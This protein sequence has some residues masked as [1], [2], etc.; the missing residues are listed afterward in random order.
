MTPNSFH[1]GDLA[2][3]ISGLKNHGALVQSRF[4][5]TYVMTRVRVCGLHDV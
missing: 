1:K 2:V 3:G 4:L 5:R